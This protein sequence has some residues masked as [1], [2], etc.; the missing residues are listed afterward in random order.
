MSLYE[1]FKRSAALEAPG[2]L[3][4]AGTIFGSM[5]FQQHMSPCGPTSH[6]WIPDGDFSCFISHLLGWYTGYITYPIYSICML[7]HLFQQL[8]QYSIKYQKPTNSLLS[9]P[10]LPS[11]AFHLFRSTAQFS[12]ELTLRLYYQWH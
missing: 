5:L 11:S 3:S 7:S 9:S 8:E 12:E 10:A 4:E 2:Y 6:H 1:L